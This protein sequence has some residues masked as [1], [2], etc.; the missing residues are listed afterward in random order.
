MKG[1]KRTFEERLQEILEE[2][3]ADWRLPTGEFMRKRLRW[4]NWGALLRYMTRVAQEEARRRRWR[5]ARDGLL[6]E[7]YAPESIAS[8]VAAVVLAGRCRLAPGWT[9][10]RLKREVGR[11]TRQE[12]R[13]LRK[14]AEASAVRS[15]WEVKAPGKNGELRSV[16]DGMQGTIRGGDEDLA[17]REEEEEREQVRARLGE[18]LNGDQVAREV[19]VC[20]CDGVVRRREIAAKLGVEVRAVTA[21]RKRLERCVRRRGKVTEGNE[22]NEGSGGRWVWGLPRRLIPKAKG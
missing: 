18:L 9:W 5:G 13:R 22:G 8:E 10:E 17:R 7:G 11:L 14:L 3:Q 19:L 1:D 16:F 6:P 12:V 15:E 4:E 20:L 2:Q 21:A